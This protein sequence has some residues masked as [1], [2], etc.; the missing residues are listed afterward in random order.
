MLSF[1]HSGA[2]GVLKKRDY[3]HESTEGMDN[4]KISQGISLHDVY[5]THYIDRI[6]GTNLLQRL[7]PQ[8]NQLCWKKLTLLVFFCVHTF[9]T[10][11]F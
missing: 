3:W 9:H 7:F 8:R 10:N 11:S 5:I 2:K 4:T 6:S 1:V